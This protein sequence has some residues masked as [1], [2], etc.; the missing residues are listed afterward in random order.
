MLFL[1]KVF[2]PLVK[3]LALSTNAVVRLLGFNPHA[4][5]ETVTEEEIRMMVDVG[6]EKGVIED[7]QKER[8]EI[9]GAT[10]EQI[11]ALADYVRAV[12]SDEAICVIGNE[13]R[14]REEENLFM[15]VLPLTNAQA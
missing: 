3:V 12:L 2:S 1:S 5:E 4:D 11:R 8:D 10:E 7:V 9:L 6:Q 14:I 13:E 15:N